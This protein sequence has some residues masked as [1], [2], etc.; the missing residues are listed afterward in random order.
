MKCPAQHESYA[1]PLGSKAVVVYVSSD[2]LPHGVSH[3]LSEEDEHFHLGG[4]S[5][6]GVRNISVSSHA[7]CVDPV[8]GTDKEWQ[9]GR[10]KQKGQKQVEAVQRGWTGVGVI[11][12]RSHE[13][14][15]KA[16]K[17]NSQKRK[18]CIIAQRKAPKKLAAN[19]FVDD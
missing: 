9:R 8:R 19:K 16:G 12:A 15:C 14:E 1:T 13:I 10:L 2:L 11:R 6:A 7:R 17:G 3:H 18:V 5:R 4:G